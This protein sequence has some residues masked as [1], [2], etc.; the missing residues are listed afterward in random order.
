MRKKDD[1]IHL[2]ETTT[3]GSCSALQ[4]DRIY[5]EIKHE[6]GVSTSNVR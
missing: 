2:Q 5:I 4:S 3:L 6:L 1:E